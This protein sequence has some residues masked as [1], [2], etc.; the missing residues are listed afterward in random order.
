M[1]RF[2]KTDPRCFVALSKGNAFL[3][4][5]CKLKANFIAKSQLLYKGCPLTRER[6][7]KKNPIMFFKSVRVRL[8]ESGR[9]RECVNTDFDWE[10]KRGFKKASVSRA[11]RLPECPLAES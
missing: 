8:R 9:L 6:K 4:I 10:V 7:Q 1:P 3:L 11:V 2:D 5:Y